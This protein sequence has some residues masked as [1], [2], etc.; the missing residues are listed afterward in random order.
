MLSAQAS[1]SAP[2]THHTGAPLV[3]TGIAAGLPGRHRSVFQP[4]N[5]RDLV[6]GVQFIT[7]LSDQ[8]KQELIDRNVVQLKKLPDGKT[9]KVP[10]NTADKVIKLAAQLG[11]FDLAGRYGVSESLCSTMDTVVQ[12]G[13]AAGLEALKDAGIVKGEEGSMASWQLPESMRDT[14]GVVYAT[15]FPALE[16]AVSEVM[17]FL[18][19]KQKSLTQAQNLLRSVRGQLE[20]ACGGS[21]ENVSS[22]DQQAYE[23][24]EK[25]LGQTM[26]DPSAEYEFDRKFLFRI[27]VLGNAQ[28]AQVIGARGPNMQTNAACAGTTQAIAIAQDIIQQGRCERLIVIASD[29]ASGDT[30][31]P[32]LGSGF[33]AL[34]AATIAG[35]VEDAALPFDK[36]RSG[37]ILGA[38]AIGIVLETEAA[39]ARRFAERQGLMLGP[40]SVV[41]SSS[42]STGSSGR[43]ASETLQEL[44]SSLQVRLIDTQYS[45]SAY[46]G[47]ALDKDHIAQELERF[48]CAIQRKFG[49]TRDT[50]AREGCYLSHETMTHASD[51]SSCAANEVFALR[52]CFGDAGMEQLILL[53][54]KGYTGHPMGVSFEDVAAVEILRNGVIPPIA[55]FNQDTVDPY[56]GKVRLGLGSD[57]TDGAYKAKYALRFA[58][59]FGSQVAFALYANVAG[60]ASE[61]PTYYEGIAGGLMMAGGGATASR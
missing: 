2:Q 13:I 12:I 36:R 57:N 30:L 29:N 39:V 59:G 31:I 16:A 42:S 44:S 25:S 41:A 9:I 51:A 45:N 33:R 5:L 48:L 27:L 24:L 32:W 26:D 19:S 37:M 60:P 56:L 14:T 15:S 3:V 35:R 4:D 20:A 53:N 61:P 1:L 21:W 46:H 52:K 10:V 23:Q 28:L 22:E 40:S 38:G 34:G 43:S 58:A 47:A 54:T 17:R 6:S 50:I 11:D 49:I 8:T 7:P 18:H 55:N